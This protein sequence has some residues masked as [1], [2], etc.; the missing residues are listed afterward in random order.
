MSK[1]KNILK[2]VIEKNENEELIEE[3]WEKL[4]K[5][6]PRLIKNIHEMVEYYANHGAMEIIN[7]IKEY[8]VSVT[9]GNHIDLEENEKL[10]L[11]EDTYEMFKTAIRNSQYNHKNKK[12]SLGR[13]K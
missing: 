11:I 9:I 3:G 5:Q 12:L 7:W 1:F 6:N 4:K 10:Q 2:E 8:I 13:F